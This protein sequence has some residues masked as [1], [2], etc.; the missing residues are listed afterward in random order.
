MIHVTTDT[1]K[2]GSAETL[3]A[4]RVSYFNRNSPLADHD[5]E[6]QKNYTASIRIILCNKC[7]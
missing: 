5:N 1:H 7:W 2:L 3:G 6:S 4:Q